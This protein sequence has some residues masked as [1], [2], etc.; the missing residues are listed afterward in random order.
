[1]TSWAGASTDNYRKHFC[2]N[3]IDEWVPACD[4]AGIAIKA[5]G[6]STRVHAWRKA[7]GQ[8]PADSVQHDAQRP[9]FDREVFIDYI[10][11][12]IV[13][14]NQVHINSDFIAI[15]LNKK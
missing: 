6:V 1:M 10:T 14:N 7:Q 12:W 2:D 13:T 3:H 4:A 11:E 9:E 8:A 5:K 15:S